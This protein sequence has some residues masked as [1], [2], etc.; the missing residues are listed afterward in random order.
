MAGRTGRIPN[1]DFLTTQILKVRVWCH[2][3]GIYPWIAVLSCLFGVLPVVDA[4]PAA[5][6]SPTD[7]TLMGYLIACVV[8]PLWMAIRPISG[9]WSVVVVWCAG[10]LLPFSFSILYLFVVLIAVGVL[11]FFSRKQGICACIVGIFMR[12]LEYMLPWSESPL[13]L[14]DILTY[15]VFFTIAVISGSALRWDKQRREQESR[16]RNIWSA[17]RLHDYTSNDLCDII[18]VVDQCL[19]TAGVNRDVRLTEIRNLASSALH[20]TRMVSGILETAQGDTR[21]GGEARFGTSLKTELTNIAMER[22]SVMSSLGLRGRILVPD[23]IENDISPEFG[24]FI[25]GLLR[26]LCNN[27]VRHADSAGG[28]AIVLS[29]TSKETIISALNS[30]RYDGSA[31]PSGTGLARYQCRVEELGGTWNMST[32][33]SKWSLRTVIPL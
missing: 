17:R 25:C 15:F 12:V 14:I 3:H 9:A 10:S 31:L 21:L 1:R 4:M 27:I 11:S 26:E 33:D 18:M 7:F 19:S 30:I 32:I 22:Q 29:M 5:F 6:H 16:R 8:T 13:G 28:Y 2:E 23:S 24:E 20:Q